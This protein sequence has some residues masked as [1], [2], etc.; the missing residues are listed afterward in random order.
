MYQKSVN[1]R[2]N[3]E[4]TNWPWAFFSGKDVIT[5]YE[6]FYSSTF[7]WTG[8]GY[9]IVTWYHPFHHL[10]QYIFWVCIHTLFSCLFVLFVDRKHK[11][12]DSG[13]NSED[14]WTMVW[15]GQFQRKKWF[16]SWLFNS[17]EDRLVGLFKHSL[18]TCTSKGPNCA[19][20]TA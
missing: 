6:S 12:A 4:Y 17:I 13:Y 14:T 9:K 11:K 18:W 8:F 5:W 19:D 2:H 3:M 15:H 1:L 10:L 20:C 7:F 16:N